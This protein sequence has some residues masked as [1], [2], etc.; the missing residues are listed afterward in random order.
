MSGFKYS[1]TLTTLHFIVTYLGLEISAIFGLFRK[2]SVNIRE[3]VPISLAFTG[4][5]IFNNL[6]LQNNTIGT[7]QLL[8]VLTTP[9]IVALQ[10]CM[11]AV[12][13][14]RRQLLALGLVCIGV[15]VATVTAVEPN[16]VGLIWGGLGILATSLYQI[17]V[18]TEQARLGLDAPQLLVHQ[19]RCS[20]VLLALVAFWF[21]GEQ[22]KHE[23]FSPN[24]SMLSHSAVWVVSSSILAFLVNLS[25]F[26]VIRKTSPVAYNVLGHAK[27]CVILLSGYLVFGEPWSVWNLVGVVMT[28][29]GIVW[30]TTIKLAASPTAA[31]P[32]AASKFG[33]R[34][35]QYM[36][37]KS[38]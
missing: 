28:V 32:A 6:S 15:A 16:R 35:V 10:L 19:A 3:V 30:Y 21:E 17:W 18:K 33:T 12:S 22:V 8:K 24:T 34:V 20:A 31:P 5:V 36:K 9:V 38:S 25:I 7:Y 14:P 23:V 13:T 2:K 4:F 37:A 26:L 11:H 27:L 1:T 29:S